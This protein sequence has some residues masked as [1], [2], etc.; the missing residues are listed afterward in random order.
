MKYILV[1][2]L[3]SPSLFGAICQ[4]KDAQKKKLKIVPENNLQIVFVSNPNK[5][6]RWK[7]LPH[8][9]AFDTKRK[10]R[11]IA[12]VVEKEPDQPAAS[13]LISGAEKCFLSVSNYEEAEHI[14]TCSAVLM[15][16]YLN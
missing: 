8:K 10:R 7:P 1:L 5:W 12:F 16:Y 14:A 4:I 13:P 15:W 6:R 11:Y 2:L 3:F 9:T